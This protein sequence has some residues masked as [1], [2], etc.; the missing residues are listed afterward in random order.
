MRIIRT[1]STR[2]RHYREPRVWGTIVANA[3][4]LRHVPCF[5]LSPQGGVPA[6]GCFP[7]SP[8]A[9]AVTVTGRCQRVKRQPLKLDHVEQVGDQRAVPNAGGDVRRVLISERSSE[10]QQN[11]VVKSGCRIISAS[12]RRTCSTGSREQP[13]PPVRRRIRA[14]RKPRQPDRRG[15]EQARPRTRRTHSRRAG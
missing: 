2:A 7:F 11:G 1:V 6:C 5:D 4:L 8:R 12:A 13:I 15:G 9:D 14:R 3:F 10:L